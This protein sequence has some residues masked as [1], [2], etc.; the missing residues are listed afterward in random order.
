M[1][2]FTKSNRLFGENAYKITILIG[3]K[4]VVQKG[5]EK[6]AKVHYNNICIIEYYGQLY[7]RLKWK[8]Q[9]RKFRI[10]IKEMQYAEHSKK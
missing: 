5:V 4:N 8:S 1:S 7:R 6:Y 9:E 2:I 3:F 10:D